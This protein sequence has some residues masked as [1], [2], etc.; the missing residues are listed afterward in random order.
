MRLIILASLLLSAP[1]EALARDH[2]QRREPDSITAI[3]VHTVGGPACIANTV[4]FRPIPKR[5]DDTQFWQG[6]L[7]AARNAEAHYVIGRSGTSAQVMAPT[8]IAYHTV[9]INDVSVGIEL[10]H[11]GDGT[12]PFEEPQIAKLIELIKDVRER[13]PK[14]S[15]SN[16]VTHSDIDQR[17]CACDGKP[18]H[19]RQ[20]PGGNFPI[21]RVIDAIRIPGDGDYGQSS[22]PRLTGPAPAS[23]CTT[24]GK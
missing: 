1:L 10:V 15:L 21:Q 6:L 12:E 9:G 19:R 13:F 14:I 11:R 5:E 2:G 8:E 7:K 20:D 24:Y 17:T 3:V 4:Q 23:A 16:V 22:L 18:Y